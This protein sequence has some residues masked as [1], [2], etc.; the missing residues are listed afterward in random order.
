MNMK[1]K[2]QIMML[3]LQ[4]RLRRRKRSRGGYEIDMCNGPLFG[5]ILRFAVPLMLSGMLQLFFNAADIIVVGQFVGH[6]ALAAVGSTGALINLLINVFIGLSVGT[7]V[8]VARY[9]GA[10]DGKQLHDTVHTSVLTSLVSGTV[11]IVIGLLL[12]EPL[13]TLMG[14]PDDVLSQAALYMRIYFVGMPAMMLYNFGAAILRAVGDTKRPLY[15]LL[16]SGI[17]NV[18]LNLILVIVFHLGVAGVSI[19]TV[20]SQVISALLVARCLIKT[21]APYRL[22]LKKLRIS[23]SKLLEIVKIGLPAGMQG[24]VFS[25]SNVLIQSTINSF[26]S[27]AMAGSTAG[28]NIEGFVWTAMDAF[29]QSTLSFTGQNYGAKKF[30]RITKVVWYNLGLVT[31]VGLVLGIGAYLV[32]PWVLQVYSSDPEVIAYGLERMLLVCTPYAL[33]GVMNVLVGA[34]RGL[35]SSLTPMVVSI[36]GVCVLRVV[37]IYTV[38]PLDPSFAMLFL[39]YPVTWAVT[40]AIEVVCFFVIRKKTI[41]RAGGMAADAD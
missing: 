25:I 1:R 6:T 2:I 28:G 40:A 34:M 12:A 36:F 22:E 15:F 18:V 24:A 9:Y 21:D 23:K 33:C 4:I 30:H 31:V 13:L 37:W 29:T 26:G 27:I 20:T 10:R 35:G 3:R 8:L 16:I 19:A 5:K 11:L 14:T 41:A 17:V 7:N 32:G 38:F 39:S